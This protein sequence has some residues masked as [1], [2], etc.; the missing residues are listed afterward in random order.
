MLTIRFHAAIAELATFNDD[1]AAGGITREVYTPTYARALDRVIAWM[2]E[3][4]LQ[5]EA[6]QFRA[7][8]P[9]NRQCAGVDA[10]RHSSPLAFVEPRHASA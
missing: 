7:D 1:P 8:V 3:A 4:G 2:R 9:L 5:T 10:R 6:A